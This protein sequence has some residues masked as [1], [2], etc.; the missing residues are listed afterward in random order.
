M[1]DYAWKVWRHISAW[2]KVLTYLRA[3]PSQAQ[4]QATELSWW[5][6]PEN[7]SL[8]ARPHNGA[9]GWTTGV[10]GGTR[11]LRP[12]PFTFLFVTIVAI[13]EVAHLRMFFWISMKAFVVRKLTLQ[14]TIKVNSDLLQT[15]PLATNSTVS[16][17]SL[18]EW[19]MIELSWLCESWG[20]S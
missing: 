10:F 3:A 12:V 11:K 16:W 18:I 20:G 13:V 1:Q 17:S 15:T 2:V 19:M 4:T 6:V 8:Q 7:I 5:N 14:L 9:L